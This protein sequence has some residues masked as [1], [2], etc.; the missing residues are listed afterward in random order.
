MN[1]ESGIKVEATVTHL[2]GTTEEV[3]VTRIS[4]CEFQAAMVMHQYH[5]GLITAEEALN[6][7]TVILI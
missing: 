5:D 4:E 2:D 1:K 3:E 6:Q 7:L